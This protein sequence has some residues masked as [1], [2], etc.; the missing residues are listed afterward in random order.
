VVCDRGV[1]ERGASTNCVRA[2]GD[3][4]RPSLRG[5]GK[6]GRWDHDR[7]RGARTFE[8]VGDTSRAFRIVVTDS[9]GTGYVDLVYVR[10]GRTLMRFAGLGDLF[11]L[12]TTLV[13]AVAARAH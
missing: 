12:E 8:R 6:P 7:E 2:H 9:E 4:R 10:R 1:R 5:K 11:P 13:K 3:D